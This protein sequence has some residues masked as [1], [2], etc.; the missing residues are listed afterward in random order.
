M[1][2]SRVALLQRRRHDKLPGATATKW[3]VTAA[4]AREAAEACAEAFE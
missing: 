2:L 1:R 4:S 3:R